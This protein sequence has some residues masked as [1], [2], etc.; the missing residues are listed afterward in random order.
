M[1]HANTRAKF[2]PHLINFCVSFIFSSQQSINKNFLVPP[3]FPWHSRKRLPQKVVKTLPRDIDDLHVITHCQ[4]E[5]HAPFGDFQGPFGFGRYENGQ[6]RGNY[7]NVPP[8]E[9]LSLNLGSHASDSASASAAAA[10]RRSQDP[11]VLELSTRIPLPSFI[12]A[13]MN[14][15]DPHAPTPA[16]TWKAEL[17]KDPDNKMLSYLPFHWGKGGECPYSVFQHTNHSASGK[18]GP[19]AKFAESD[20]E[21]RK[22][23]ESRSRSR[24]QIDLAS[25]C[26]RKWK[27]SFKVGGVVSLLFA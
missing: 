13:V 22:L 23:A 19:D 2:R 24:A 12:D 21:S 25:S 4:D 10:A 9:T 27:I 20:V 7:S 11:G 1:N 18:Q 16:A 14:G 8:S 17:S 6:S 26:M 5:L 15:K 3:Y